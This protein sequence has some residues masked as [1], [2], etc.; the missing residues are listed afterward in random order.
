ML[1]ASGVLGELFLSSYNPRVGFLDRE[2]VPFV[3]TDSKWHGKW[4]EESGDIRVIE[5]KR[6]GNKPISLRKVQLRAPRRKSLG[7]IASA[8][9]EE[10]V[11][12]TRRVLIGCQLE[13]DGSC[14]NWVSPWAHNF[15]DFELNEIEKNLQQMKNNGENPHVISFYEKLIWLKTGIRS[16]ATCALLKNEAE[17]FMNGFTRL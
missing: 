4:R 14:E 7:E 16:V 2:L 8:V 17:T 13:V 12:K 11:K 15:L 3:I 9:D 1:P 5:R 6:Y 10:Y